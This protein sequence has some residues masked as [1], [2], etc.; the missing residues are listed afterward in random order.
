MDEYQEQGE[1]TAVDQWESIEMINRPRWPKVIG[2]LSIIWGGIGTVCGGL[3]MLVLPFSSQLSGMALQNGEP[4]P[5]G[6]V[7]TATDYTIGAIGF[8]LAVLL[9][10]AG[11]SCV[12]YRPVTR[13]MH[14]LYGLLSIPIVVWSYLNQQ[15]KLELN[16][17]WAKEFPDN[18]IAQSYNGGGGGAAIGQVIGLV[19][20]IVLGFGVPLFYLIWFGL[21]KTKPE[22]ITGGDE[23]VY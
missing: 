21:I 1:S 14:L 18:P 20:L 5:Y 4:T 19:V 8:G 12:S 7:P 11:I 3:G 10:F 2:I 6:N 9:V 22:Q 23:G 13:M 16:M 17:Q 15:H